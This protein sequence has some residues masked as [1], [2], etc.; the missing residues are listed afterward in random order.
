[1][2]EVFKIHQVHT[3]SSEGNLREIKSVNHERWVN[4][5]PTWLKRLEER[6]NVDNKE[7]TSNCGC[8]LEVMHGA[9][10]SATEEI[11]K[12]R[13]ELWGGAEG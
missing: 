11:D 3:V 9:V 1:M 6:T 10:N 4:K 2:A 8:E 5:L 12:T 7:I 13:L